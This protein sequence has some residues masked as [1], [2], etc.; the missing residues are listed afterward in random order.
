MINRLD[1]INIQKNDEIN[2]VIEQYNPNE[3][4]FMTDFFKN[5]ENIKNKFILINENIDT[6]QNISSKILLS[7]SIDIEIVF[8]EKDP[9]N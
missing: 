6:F 3:K 2:V 8:M 4:D 1:E 9:S 5:V 7:T